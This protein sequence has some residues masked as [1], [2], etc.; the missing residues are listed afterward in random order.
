MADKIKPLKF[1]NPA[2]GGT[3]VDYLP[4]EAKPSE[5]YIAAKGIAFENND[6]RLIDL[7]VSGEVQWRDSVQTTYKKLNDIVS[8]GFDVDAILTND[9]EVLMDE[10]GRV[11]VGV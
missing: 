1:E 10:F 6:L 9:F 11:L 7:S 3:Q 2:S 5:D 8:G 4:T